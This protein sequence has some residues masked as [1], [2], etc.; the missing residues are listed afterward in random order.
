MDMSK[1]KL[2]FGINSREPHD[3]ARPLKGA[4][5]L[6]SY[7]F[8][9][10][11]L[12]TLFAVV[13]LIPP[14]PLFYFEAK[15]LKLYVQAYMDSVL[16]PQGH[17]APL[18][19]TTL[20]DLPVCKPGNHYE[21]KRSSKGYVNTRPSFILEMPNK[22]ATVDSFLQQANNTLG[23]SFREGTPCGIDLANWMMTNKEKIYEME[24]CGTSKKSMT[25]EE[26]GEY[27]QK[28]LAALFTNKS[29]QHRIPLDKFMTY[30]HIKWFLVEHCGYGHWDQ[31]PLNL[32]EA[33]LSRRN[34]TYPNWDDT[35]IPSY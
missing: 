7:V 14:Q 5:F 11:S 35:E 26:Y 4:I 8:P 16:E 31:L 34:Q 15:F 30:G 2:S 29:I 28:H 18:Y 3:K 19:M 25:H 33:I 1:V 24:T 27:L 22:L 9:H 23:S 32:R 17:K 6:V 20:K 21:Y 12:N 10:K 13:N